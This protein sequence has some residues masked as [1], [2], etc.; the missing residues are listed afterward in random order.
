MKSIAIFLLVLILEIPQEVIARDGFLCTPKEVSKLF[1]MSGERE[2]K[3]CPSPNSKVCNSF[4]VAKDAF[5][6]TPTH[7]S[8]LI[9][10]DSSYKKKMV[11]DRNT[12]GFFLETIYKIENASS[13]ETI[14]GECQPQQMSN[15]KL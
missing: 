9:G 15:Q 11:V 8:W 5:Q 12:A 10:D 6:V 3:K 7:Y 2:I 1:I 14:L 13:L 4:L